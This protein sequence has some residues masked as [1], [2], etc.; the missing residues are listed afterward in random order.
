MAKSL[1]KKLLNL[2]T[3]SE[4]KELNEQIH[5]ETSSEINETAEAVENSSA[6]NIEQEEIKTEPT[7]EEKLAELNDRYLRLYSEFD[8]YRKRTNKEK[9]DLIA[10][11]SAGVLKELITTLDDFERAIANNENVE[12]LTTLKEGFHLI[13]NKL[14][15]TLENKG[16]KAML[17]KGESF[18]SELHEA[19]ANIPAPSED[20]VG[21]IVEDV[22]KG[23]YLHDK[24]IRYAKVVVGQ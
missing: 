3:M 12:D 14:K 9:I 19:I 24:V 2:I 10:T 8:N 20:L 17:A 21:K 23:Y 11:A 7:P 18:D 13:Y 1:L 15:T 5:S 6:E 16:L 4:E 22:E